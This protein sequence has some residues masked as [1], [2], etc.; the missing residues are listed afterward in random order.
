MPGVAYTT[1]SAL[2]H[3]H[4]EIHFSLTYIAQIPAALQTAE[5][6]GVLVH[7]MVHCWQWAGLSTAPGGLIEGVADFVRLKA[8]LSPPHW[9]KEAGGDWDA[10]YQH[11]G[12]FLEW[13]EERFGEGSVEKVNAGLK[14]KKYVEE[15]FWR[16]LFGKGVAELWGEYGRGVEREGGEKKEGG[17]RR[18]GKDAGEVTDDEGVLVE[19]EDEAREDEGKKGE[20][21]VAREQAKPRVKRDARKEAEGSDAGKAK[22]NKGEDEDEKPPSYLV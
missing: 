8:G 5:I 6:M 19:R 3:D 12:Y 10:G 21:K 9:K 18:E 17:E 11:T 13:V 14:G 15:E 7:E 2:D 4:K 22:V 1:G 16:G 20:K